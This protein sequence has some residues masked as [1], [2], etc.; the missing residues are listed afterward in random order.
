MTGQ[1]I[2]KGRGGDHRQDHAPPGTRLTEQRVRKVY[3]ALEQISDKAEFNLLGVETGYLNYEYWAPGC[4]D[5]HEACVVLAERRPRHHRPAAARGRTAEP[6]PA[7]R[8]SAP[9]A[10]HPG[11][12]LVPALGLRQAARRGRLR[13]RRRPEHHRPDPPAAR[14]VHTWHC[15]RLLSDPRFKALKSR[16]TIRH[17]P[18]QVAG[19][20]TARD[21]ILAR[22][23]KPA[24]PS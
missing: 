5:H 17:Y 18:K 12:E 3:Q 16:N 8:R 1:T 6:A 23:E 13:Q 10:H 2:S 9:Q 15:A 14:G 21:Y 11:R 24:T 22:A 19:R 20:V 4:T 7:D